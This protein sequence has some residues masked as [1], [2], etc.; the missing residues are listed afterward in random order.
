MNK[1]QTVYFDEECVFT[2]E[3]KAGVVKQDNG[4][5][6]SIVGAVLFS[7]KDNWV[8]GR[9]LRKNLLTQENYLHTITWEQLKKYTQIIYT[10]VTYDYM[11]RIYT[12]NEDQYNAVNNSPT[13]NL[14]PV[15]YAYSSMAR[16]IDGAVV[17]ENYT[18]IDVQVRTNSFQLINHQNVDYLFDGIAIL[19]VPY[20]IEA[21]DLYNPMID[22]Q[23]LYILALH[24]FPGEKL[25]ILH[26]QNNKLVFNTEIHLFLRDDITVDTTDLY[27]DN[28]KMCEGLHIVNDGTSNKKLTNIMSLGGTTKLLLS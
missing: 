9:Y 8:Y 16:E 26:D 7:D 13:D 24:Y 3:G 28:G 17:T 14:L 2:D 11:E 23:N 18:S 15:Q 12:P 10:K 20:K 27:P 1:T 22:Y 25:K 21:S 4:Y 5:K 6:F 19:A